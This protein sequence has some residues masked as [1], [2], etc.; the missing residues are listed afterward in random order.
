MACPV[1]L[2]TFLPPLASLQAVQQPERDAECH[3]A[4]SGGQLSA[5]QLPV[6]G[7]TACMRMRRLQFWR[8]CICTTHLPVYTDIGQQWDDCIHFRSLEVSPSRY[9]LVDLKSS[10]QRLCSAARAVH[11]AAPA[12]PSG[13]ASKRSWPVFH[14]AAHALRAALLSISHSQQLSPGLA[15]PPAPVVLLVLMLRSVPPSCSIPQQLCA[16][17]HHQWH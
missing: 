11:L 6:C 17:T 14:R 13:P 12:P 9:I 5:A 15:P 8:A 7:L 2:P 16:S 3:A 10:A 4:A 1:Q